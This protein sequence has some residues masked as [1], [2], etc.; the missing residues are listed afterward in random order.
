MLQKLS[1]ECPTCWDK[2]LDAAL[3]A[4]RSQV[5]SAT[6]FFPFYL[7]FGRAPSGP[8]A[9]LHNL[10]TRQNESADTYFQY[11]YI[12]DLHNKIKA[13]CRIAQDSASE[14]A[15]ASRQRH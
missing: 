7:L 2:Y 1:N 9:M 14:V 5:H 4:Y 8:M 12:I 11:H 3:Y 6:G 15:E 13:S 10:F